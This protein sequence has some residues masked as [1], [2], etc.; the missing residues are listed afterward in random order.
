MT[1]LLMYGDSCLDGCDST[2]S[3]ICFSRLLRYVAVSRLGIT[4]SH[5]YKNIIKKLLEH[6]EYVFRQQ[7]VFDCIQIHFIITNRDG[8]LLNKDNQSELGLGC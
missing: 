4:P 6:L 1:I 8:A 2:I 7:Y 5:G 3:W